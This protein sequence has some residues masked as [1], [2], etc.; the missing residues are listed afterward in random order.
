MRAVKISGLR[1]Q[2]GSDFALNIPQLSVNPGAILCVAGPNGSGKTTF[3]ESIAGLITPDSGEILLRG[4]IVSNDRAETQ[5]I[6]GF[7]PDD[8]AWFIKEL[9]AS[10][11]LDV[12]ESV[13]KKAG[14]LLDMTKRVRAI[15]STLHFTAFDQPLEQLSHGNKKKV[16]IIAALMHEPQVIICDEL[17]N[18]LDPLAIIAIER[19]LRAEAKRGACVIAATHDL[20]WA[21]R[22]ADTVLLLIDGRVA[23][24]EKTSDI[25]RS[26]GS[27]EN[28]FMQ[29]VGNP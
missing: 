29:A 11:Y 16:Q 22:L 19:L 13:Y 1:L 25:V 10:E 5:A 23:V 2:R 20:W 14:V 17:R 12:L 21:E 27:L 9:S 18:G 8:E 6:M 24:L 28:L 26:N 4:H 7:I 3:I 15:A